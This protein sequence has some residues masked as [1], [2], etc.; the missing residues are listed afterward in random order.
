MALATT[1]KPFALIY[2]PRLRDE[3]WGLPIFEGVDVKQLSSGIGHYPES[4]MPDEDGNF[5]LFGHRTSYGQP[6]SN[7]QKLRSGDQ[8]FVEMK[9]FWFVY[10]LKF[11]RIVKPTALWVTKGLRHPELGLRNNDPLNVITLVTCEPRY[12][13]AKRWVWWGNLQNVYSRQEL[14][15]DLV[16]LISQNKP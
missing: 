5:S 1:H 15:L 11:D 16:N 9:D 10:E 12:S 4:N 8:V 7:I 13:T 14:P 3:V 2:I 6:L